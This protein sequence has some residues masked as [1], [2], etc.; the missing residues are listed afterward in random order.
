MER[1]KVAERKK[2]G[3]N[4][5]RVASLRATPEQEAFLDERREQGWAT[6]AVLSAALDTY[7]EQCRRAKR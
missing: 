6:S 2:P 7:M 3:R 4:F 5:G 1:N